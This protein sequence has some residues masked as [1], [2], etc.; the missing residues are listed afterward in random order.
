LS[1][2]PIEVT[3]KR[4]GLMSRLAICDILSGLNRKALRLRRRHQHGIDHMDHAVRLVDVRD[5]DQRGATLG[6]DQPNL[7][8]VG[9]HRQ[10]F[11]PASWRR[12]LRDRQY[13]STWFR[14]PMVEV[15]GRGPPAMKTTTLVG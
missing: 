6:V 3:K 14:L 1:W 2:G 15:T 13:A 7:T 5:R 11:A 9:V 4:A 8:P 10:R 12:R